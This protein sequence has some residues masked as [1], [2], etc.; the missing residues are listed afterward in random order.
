MTPLEVM[1]ELAGL[2]YRLHLRPGGVRLAGTGTPPPGLVARIREHRDALV[3]LL[4]DEDRA[5]AAHETSLAAGR[6]T[7]FPA[8]LLDLVHPSLRVLLASENIQM[9]R[10]VMDHRSFRGCDRGKS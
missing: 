10:T 2:G 9:S 7:T 1:A 6:V 8:H 5:R 4:E 3:G